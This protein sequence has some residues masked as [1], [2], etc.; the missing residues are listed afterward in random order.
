MYVLVGCDV[1]VGCV[2]DLV[3]VFD[4]FVCR[5]GVGCYFVVGGNE[6]LDFEVVF[7]L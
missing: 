5:D 7:V 3:V 1:L 6:V 4:W 2:D